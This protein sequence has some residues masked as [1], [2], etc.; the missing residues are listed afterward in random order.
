[1]CKITNPISII[2]TL[3]LLF[4]FYSCGERSVAPHP[5]FTITDDLGVV[6]SFDSI[7]KRIISLAPNITETLFAIGADSQVVGVTDLCDYPPEAKLKTKTGSYI[8]PDYETISSLNPDLIIINVE[9][10]SNPNYQALKNLGM[11]LFV[12][13]AGNVDEIFKMIKD[14]GTITGKYRGS[15][16]LFTRLKNERAALRSEVKH[17]SLNYLILISI[18][19]LMTTNGKTFINEILKLAG[20][21]NMYSDLSIEYPE[22]SYEDVLSRDPDY[23][24]FPADTSDTEKTMKFTNE[25]RRQLKDTKAVKE[26]KI[27]I[28]DGNTM[29]RPGPRIFDAV[30]IL[31]SKVNRVF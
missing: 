13:K 30:R 28:T 23:I 1:M 11:K 26:N 6:V 31:K 27:I 20:V 21:K 22:V 10:L 29:F 7:P 15:D 14:F 5:K 3:L 8:S 9:N 19:P 18:S 17:D 16:T 2:P 25:I 24:I 4:I 12:S